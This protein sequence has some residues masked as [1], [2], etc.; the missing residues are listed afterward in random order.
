MNVLNFKQCLVSF[1]RSYFKR[2]VL[3]NR[4]QKIKS[5]IAIGHV[6][7]F[8][9]VCLAKIYAWC[10][11]KCVAFNINYEIQSR[12]R[13]IFLFGFVRFFII[14]NFLFSPSCFL[15]L[16]F[17]NANLGTTLTTRSILIISG[18]FYLF[19]LPLYFYINIFLKNIK[20]HP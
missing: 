14:V 15:L 8:V 2:E 4:K 5:C 13:R 9:Q 18:S 19:L 17:L 16:L 7:F 1:Y 11:N 20:L 12:F 3:Q 6:F 10:I